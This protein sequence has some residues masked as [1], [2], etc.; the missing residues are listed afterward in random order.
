MDVFLILNLPKICESSIK[1]LVKL[2]FFQQNIT[3]KMRPTNFKKLY[4]SVSY[5]QQYVHMFFRN[6]KN[7]KFVS[8]CQFSFVTYFSANFLQKN[9]LW[10]KVNV[11]V[12][13]HFFIFFSINMSND[14][15][16]Y[17]NHYKHYPRIIK[18]KIDTSCQC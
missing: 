11:L 1:N 14:K 18:N 15:K 3:F 10:N 4:F 9:V 13:G 8:F 2:Y 16:R 12:C 17:D 5:D 7:F 6:M